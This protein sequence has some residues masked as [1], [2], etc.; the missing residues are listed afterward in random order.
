MDRDWATA[1]LAR[2]REP[3]PPTPLRCY[4]LPFDLEL[5]LK[6]ESQRPS[7]S[8]KH[9]IV[10]RLF[11]DAVADGRIG[12]STTVVEAT[13]GNTA[14]AAAWFARLLGLPFV[15]V[16]PGRTSPAKRQR[17]E[18]YGGRCHPFDPPL[19]IYAEASRLAGELGG[20]YLDH[21]NAV[22][23][24]EDWRGFGSTGAALV[25][26]VTE[27]CGSAP[28]WVVVGAG[29]GATSATL[30][31]HLRYHGLPTRLAVVDP[32][33][34]AYFP[35]W[36]TGDRGYGT[37]MPSRID[38][39]GRPRVEPAFRAEVLDFVIPVPDAASLTAMRHL[40]AATGIEAGPSTGANLWGAFTLAAR[41]IRDG[42]RGAI[43]TLI[44][45]GGYRADAPESPQYAAAIGRFLRDGTTPG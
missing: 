16:V 42:E 33:H 15:A 34:S 28:A 7:G 13:A 14:V 5:Y 12:P 11:E 10:R 25:A 32:E 24:A 23:H 26:Q 35:S 29:T 38:G 40:A 43:A 4:P 44:A 17:I 18:S 6:D 39:I 45:D 2:L 37:G 9:G 1:A 22:E 8:L 20:H 31:R 41:M 21:L 30:G 19:A 27:A 36:A 3:E